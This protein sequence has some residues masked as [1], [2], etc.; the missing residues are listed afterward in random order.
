MSLVAE[1]LAKAA[2]S[3][4]DTVANKKWSHLFP[5]IQKLETNGFSSWGAVGWLVKSGGVPEGSERTCYH[6]Y[7]AHKKRKTTIV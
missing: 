1:L 6:S 2:T 3:K 4:P 7:L 5:V